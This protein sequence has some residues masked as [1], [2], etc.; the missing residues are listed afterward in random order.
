ME[1][2]MTDN[3]PA[4]TDDK[5]PPR[6][7]KKIRAA[8]DAFVHGDAKNITAAAEKA[9]L[10]RSHLSRELGRPHIAKYLHEK[11]FRNL[12][13]NGAKAGATKVQLLDSA[14]DMVRDRASSFILG[15]TGIVPASSSDVVRSGGG[16]RAGWVIDLSDEQSPGVVIHIVSPAP[17]QHPGEMIDVTPNEAEILPM[18]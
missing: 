1:T 11:V 18:K 13:I 12:T 2:T 16:A 17:R 14:N 8:I 3:L 5:P 6:I 4:K 15:L 9:G 10:T 7:T